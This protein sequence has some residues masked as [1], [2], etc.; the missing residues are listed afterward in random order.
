MALAKQLLSTGGRD[1]LSLVSPE[2]PTQSLSPQVQSTKFTVKPLVFKHGGLRA[3][4][5]LAK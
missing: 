5:L 1:S 2:D 3:Q 4:R